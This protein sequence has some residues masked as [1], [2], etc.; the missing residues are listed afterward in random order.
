MIDV[1][2]LLLRLE[3]P[4]QSWGISS[5]FSERDTGLEPSK[6]GI[7]GLL[8]AALGKPRLEVPQSDLPT[9][10]QLTALRMGVRVDRPGTMG[11]DFQSI[12]GGQFAGRSYGVVKANG[13]TPESVLSRRYFLQDAVFLVGLQGD[14]E[15][16]L[17]RLHNALRKPVWPLFLGRKSYVPACPP[18][19]ADG[20]QPGTLEEVLAR[21]PFFYPPEEPRVR[22]VLE[23]AHSLGCERRVDVPLDFARRRFGVRYVTNVF[24]N[25]GERGEE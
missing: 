19:L 11:V 4:M 2:T 17:S 22:V 10:A 24:V 3:G 8:C 23:Q 20:L 12:G 14:D 5:R 25:T 16:L 7:I 9:L 21:Y 18:Y 15:V 1:P 6:S 13:G